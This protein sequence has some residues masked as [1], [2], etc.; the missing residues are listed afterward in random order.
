MKTVRRMI[1]SAERVG[2][3]ARGGVLVVVMGKTF[4]LPP[5]PILPPSLSFV[6][7]P[8][9]VILI[10]LL[11]RAHPPPREALR[12]IT[13]PWRAVLSSVAISRSFRHKLPR[14]FTRNAG[15][16]LPRRGSHP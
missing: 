12:G 11:R 9:L 2:A 7:L 15:N 10:L 1:G 4:H 16:P 6:L 13:T 5:S 8:L 14:G 3:G